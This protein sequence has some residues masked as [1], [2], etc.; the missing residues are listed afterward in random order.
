MM[1][2]FQ[3]WVKK[4]QSLEHLPKKRIEISTQ[5]AIS[6]NM[7]VCMTVLF[8]SLALLPL[9]SKIFLWVSSQAEIYD[10]EDVQR[11]ICFRI[12]VA[13]FSDVCLVPKK[14]KGWENMNNKSREN[15]YNR[16]RQVYVHR[17]KSWFLAEGNMDQLTSWVTDDA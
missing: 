17:V 8:G 1:K 5:F 7:Y 3:F 10:T 13:T 16:Q 12:V 4:Q 6:A 9:I 15:S 11:S 14:R 2:I